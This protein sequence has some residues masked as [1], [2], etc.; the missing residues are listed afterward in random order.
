V[1]VTPEIE[2]PA[3]KR[4]PRLASRSG[5]IGS[6]GFTWRKPISPLQC[7]KAMRFSLHEM[8]RTCTVRGELIDRDAE[9]P[10]HA[11]GDH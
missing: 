11:S 8:K 10:S 4:L 6:G 1:I 5:S 2:A 7:S 9:H 3:L